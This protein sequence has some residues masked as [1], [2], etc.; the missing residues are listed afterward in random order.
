M[1]SNLKGRPAIAAV[2][3]ATVA[4]V[5]FA[6]GRSDLKRIAD[7]QAEGRNT[8]A[9][10]ADIGFFRS[11]GGVRH[12][13][14]DLDWRDANGVDHFG[15]RVSVS[16]VFAQTHGAHGRVAIRYA[17]RRPGDLPLIAEDE[18]YAIKRAETTYQTGQTMIAVGVAVGLYIAAM[19]AAFQYVRRMRTV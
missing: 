17:P 15:Q 3:I 18:A 10:I 5:S 6:S 11:K 14:V 12:W 9:D 13:W 7:I 2:S 1:I 8:R 4:V 16:E 19:F